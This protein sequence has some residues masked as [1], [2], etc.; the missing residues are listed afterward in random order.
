MDSSAAAA[1]AVAAERHSGRKA[2]TTGIADE[3]IVQQGC[4]KGSEEL[5]VAGC[6]D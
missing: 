2:K 6:M 5:P 4:G 3:E 1:A